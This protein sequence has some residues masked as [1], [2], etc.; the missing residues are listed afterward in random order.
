[1]STHHTTGV[2]KEAYTFKVTYSK[3]V[4]S[5]GSREIMLNS[6]QEGVTACLGVP[7]PYN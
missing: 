2:R 5:I 1:M 3:Q 7:F 6:C 4:L